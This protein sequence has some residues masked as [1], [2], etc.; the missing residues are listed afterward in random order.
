M[1]EASGSSWK[2]F[3]KETNIDLLKRKHGEIVYT[4]L[5]ERHKIE[6][7]KAKIDRRTLERLSKSDVQHTYAEGD[8]I[9]KSHMDVLLAHQL[10][11]EFA[12]DVD[13][14]LEQAVAESDYEY[15]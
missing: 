8:S 4:L 1:T 7:N 10:I 15:S 6:H 11:R 5:Q 3:A 14:A 9:Q 13:K 12:A 2:A